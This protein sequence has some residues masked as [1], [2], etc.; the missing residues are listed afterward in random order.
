MFAT[1]SAEGGVVGVIVTERAFAVP[2]AVLTVPV[3]VAPAIVA[4]LASVNCTLTV[5]VLQAS[6]IPPITT[7][8]TSYLLVELLKVVV[9]EVVTP[10][11]S[12]VATAALLAP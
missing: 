6:A 2:V 3:P 5:F 11:G 10:S 9:Y 4:V 8:A 12:Q 7:V 1:D